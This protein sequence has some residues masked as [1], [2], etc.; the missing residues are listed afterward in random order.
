MPSSAKDRFTVDFEYL[1]FFTKSQRYYF[2]TQY[3]PLDSPMHSAGN[4]KST[5]IFDLGRRI[6]YP[7]VSDPDRIWG[8]QFGR[9]KRCVWKIATQPFSDAHFAVFPPA[10]VKTPLLATC[11][12]Y[13][14]KRCGK[15]RE[16]IIETM[17]T[18]ENKPWGKPSDKYSNEMGYGTT[19]IINKSERVEYKETGLTDCRCNAGFDGGLVLDPFAGAGYCSFGG[20]AKRP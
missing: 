17:N 4:K 12:E 2:E 6:Q 18:S 7:Q 5:G 14:C 11:P 20:N 13:I 1:F 10:L 19:S 9:I 3:E 15:A 16:K 8:N